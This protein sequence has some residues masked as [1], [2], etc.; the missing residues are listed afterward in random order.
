MDDRREFSAIPSKD[1]DITVGCPLTT[2]YRESIFHGVNVSN[3][4]ASFV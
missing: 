1:M 2:E 4:S 3:K